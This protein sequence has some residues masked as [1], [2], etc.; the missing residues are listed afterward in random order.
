MTEKHI[1]NFI[2]NEFKDYKIKIFVDEKGINYLNPND[3]WLGSFYLK[4]NEFYISVLLYNNLIKHFNN[5]DEM[6]EFITPIIE[7]IINR[8]LSHFF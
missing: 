5:Q 7:K 3:R 1:I 2:N 6:H 4:R 8:K